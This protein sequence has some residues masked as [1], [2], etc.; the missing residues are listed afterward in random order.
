MLLYTNPKYDRKIFY[1]I[2]EMNYINE[3]NDI[4]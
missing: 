4:N 1:Y 2:H 3:I